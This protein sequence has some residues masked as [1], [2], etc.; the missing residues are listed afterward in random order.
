MRPVVGRIS[1]PTRSDFNAKGVLIPNAKIA[2]NAK[3]NEEGRLDRATNSA[4]L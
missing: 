4:S 1:E 3:G 2:K